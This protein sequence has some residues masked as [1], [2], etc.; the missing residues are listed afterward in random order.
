[1]HEKVIDLTFSKKNIYNTPPDCLS[2]QCIQTEPPPNISSL[3]TF[4]LI[5]IRFHLGFVWEFGDVLSNH[6]QISLRLCLGVWR[7]REGKA[8]EG[9]K[10]RGKWENLSHFLKE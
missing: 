2:I 10:Y 9:W 3:Q 8:L 7:G 4:Y 1:L 5:I 6:H